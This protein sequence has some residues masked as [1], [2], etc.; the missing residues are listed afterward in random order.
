MSNQPPRRPLEPMYHR[1]LGWYSREEIDSTRTKTVGVAGAGGDGHRYADLVRTFPLACIKA[2]DPDVV[3]EDGLGRFAIAG[4][5]DVGRLKVDVF[6]DH[7]RG[8]PV[9]TEVEKYPEG[10][11]HENVESFVEGCDLIVEEVDL[12]HLDIAIDLHRTAQR[13]GKPVL[14][15]MNVGFMGVGTSIKPGSRHSYETM[16]GID[17]R[18]PFDEIAE[19]TISPDKLIPVLPWQYGDVRVLYALQDED[20]KVP[21]PSIDVGVDMAAG[22]GMTQAGL[23]LVKGLNNHR[24][25][26]V[27]APRWAYHDAMTNKAG[28]IRPSVARFWGSAAL[29]KL[30]SDFGLNPR[31]SYDVDTL[32]EQGII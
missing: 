32:R 9:E 7:V 28:V 17:P 13:M 14:T 24:P 1:A 31:T 10:I 29:L 4:T 5:G 21:F 23:H 25:E 16:L 19:M 15:T 18:T 3:T 30:R 2:A 27:W 6:E 26:P 8:L 20:A 11:T 22:I 12:N